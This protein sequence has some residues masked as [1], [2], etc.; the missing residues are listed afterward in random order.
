MP[1]AAS[2]ASSGSVSRLRTSGRI[3]DGSSPTR[4]TRPW[5]PFLAAPVMSAHVLAAGVLE[6]HAPAAARAIVIA[7]VG[8]DAAETVGLH[9]MAELSFGIGI[10]S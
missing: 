4:G 2:L 9:S 5:G 10:A 3:L 8:A 6:P 7:P 1:S